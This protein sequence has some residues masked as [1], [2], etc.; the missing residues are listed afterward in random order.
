MT[1]LMRLVPDIFR[2]VRGACRRHP[3][4]PAA[5]VLLAALLFSLSAVRAADQARAGATR[6]Q[7]NLD[8]ARSLAE[9]LDRVVPP[10]MPA[11]GPAILTRRLEQGL[12]AAG[13]PA[14]GAIGSLALRSLGGVGGLPMS[15]HQARIE[16]TALTMR[17][18]AVAIDAIESSGTPVWLESVELQAAGTSEDRWDAVVLVQW[19]ASPNDTRRG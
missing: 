11:D 10:Q 9:A 15:R 19:L 13:V 7:E 4:I 16:L 5:V 2:L 17:Q 12:A 14:E 3:A 18:V 1:L 8:K 6:R